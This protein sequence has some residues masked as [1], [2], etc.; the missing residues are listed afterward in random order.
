ME[1]GELK[2]ELCFRAKKLIRS[3]PK[4]ELD[5]HDRHYLNTKGREASVSYNIRDIYTLANGKCSDLQGRTAKSL[6]SLH[7]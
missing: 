1:A 6:A 5:T 7:L 2:S 3:F 4:A